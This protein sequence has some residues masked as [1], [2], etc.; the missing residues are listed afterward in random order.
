MHIGAH[1]NQHLRSCRN[2]DSAI[3][4]SKQ[5]R[6]NSRPPNE[7]G[8]EPVWRSADIG[9]Q[10]VSPRKHCTETRR[11]M[12]NFAQ[13]C[14][15]KIPVSILVCCPTPSDV[16]RSGRCTA[17]VHNTSMRVSSDSKVSC[18]STQL[19]LL[20]LACATSVEAL[21]LPRSSLQLTRGSVQD[22]SQL[23]SLQ[24][25]S[26]LEHGLQPLATA[27]RNDCAPIADI[28]VA[29]HNL[30]ADELEVLPHICWQPGLVP[31]TPQELPLVAQPSPDRGLPPGVDCEATQWCGMSGI[32]ACLCATSGF[33]STSRA[34]L[35]VIMTG[36]TVLS[37]VM[38]M[39]TPFTMRRLLGAGAQARCAPRCASA[40][41]SKWSVG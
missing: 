20:L 26:R 17:F 16:A 37:R 1:S 19:A 22:A 41:P 21:D 3:C 31:P 29:G 39:L 28:P 35:L 18:A 40:A 11:A 7:I 23:H 9:S 6:R 4:T 25:A 10:H 30:T 2:F 32:P 5:A 14:L 33:H 36:C 15:C 27:Q 38:Y 8:N 12:P 24:A 13:T 34:P